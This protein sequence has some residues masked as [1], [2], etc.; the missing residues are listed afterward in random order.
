M[1]VHKQTPLVSVIIPAFNSQK[2]IRHC[3]E[4]IRRQTYERIETIIVDRHSTDET[5][6]I[7]EGFAARLFYVTQ[8]RSTAKN[9]GAR[10]A[11]GDFLL[12]VDA[13]MELAPRTTEECVELCGHGF[14]AVVVP[15][16]TFAVGF[17][18]MCKQLEVELYNGDPNFFLMPRFFKKDKY[19]AVGGF[20]ETLVCGEDFD[21]ARRYEQQSYRVGTASSP[22]KHLEGKLSLK[23]IVLKA[24]YYGKTLIPFFSKEPALALRGYCPTRFVRNVRRLMR[25]PTCLLGLGL[26]KTCEY[27]GY[28]TGVL[29]DTLGRFPQVG[30][31]N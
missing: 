30:D 27:V 7:A 13:D 16:A 11:R 29:A 18:A 31:G 10:K 25:Q 28:A 2:T 3:L 17:L 20:D 21:L 22:I 26:I 23:G 15:L 6:K 14:D 9:I 24:H 19:V 1:T 8:E 4:S 5:V 12:F